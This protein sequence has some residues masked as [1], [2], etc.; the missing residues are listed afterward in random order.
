MIH[1]D[2][3]PFSSL[4]TSGEDIVISITK[5]LDNAN[6]LMSE[7]NAERVSRML[8]H[9]ELTTETL[10]DH[11]GEIGKGLTQFSS[12]VVEFENLATKMEELVD[13]QGREFLDS[14]LASVQALEALLAENRS[15]LDNGMQGLGELGP[16]VKDLRATLRSLQ[17]LS[18]RL[19]DDPGDF[20]FGRESTQEFTP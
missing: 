11:R 12:M 1:A 6:K 17:R 7:E 2:P 20:L 5:L 15:N 9:L 19:E 10:A 4:V 13:Q 18:E 16:A 8:T 14:A 3:S